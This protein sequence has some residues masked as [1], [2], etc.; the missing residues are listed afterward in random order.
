M[1]DRVLAPAFAFLAAAIF[2]ISCPSNASAA[3]PSGIWA[4]DDG[5]AKVEIK[6]CGRG[7]CGSVVWLRNPND[8]RGR[9]LH[10]VRNENA[11]LRGRPIIGLPL[12]SNM[13][14]T[15]AN[16]WAGNV[17][18]P[19]EGRIYT[20]VK[21][22][23]VSSRQIVLRGC[24][25]WLMCGEKTWTR[26]TLPADATTP[27]LI[28]VKAPAEPAPT[29]KAA[30]TFVPQPQAPMIEASVKREALSA[31]GFTLVSTSASQK[32]LSGEDVLSMV[33]M[34]GVAPAPTTVAPAEPTVAPS[35]ATIA[36]PLTEIA[37]AEEQTETA[38][39]E[40]QWPWMQRRSA[41]RASN[42]T[43]IQQ[44]AA[45][46]EPVL[47]KPKP[48]PFVMASQAQWPWQRRRL[49]AAAQAPTPTPAMPIVVK[50]KP[51]PVAREAQEQ[52]PW[53]QRRPVVVVATQTSGY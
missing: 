34:T 31:P 25:T 6:K 19:V 17:Y 53:V 49:R 13:R 8:S 36:Q 4:K 38:A 51:K 28:E 26:S 24:R 7:L 39:T 40:E 15:G 35:A 9:P 5:S 44:Q 20:D 45:P 33:A 1:E 32:P 43:A 46:A 42:R 50:A 30:P 14:P 3:D 41:Q 23:L 2:A 47:A 11:S 37:A 12:F 16:S 21:V 22:T 48:K 10:D 29:E 18:N 52:W 27:E